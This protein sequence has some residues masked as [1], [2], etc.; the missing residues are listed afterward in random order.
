MK[1]IAQLRTLNLANYTQDWLGSQL[2]SAHDSC[3]YR[4]RHTLLFLYYYVL[5]HLQHL[6][7]PKLKYA[8][9]MHVHAEVSYRRQNSAGYVKQCVKGNQTSNQE[10]LISNTIISVSIRVSCPQTF[11]ALQQAPQNSFL[12]LPGD[13]RATLAALRKAMCLNGPPPK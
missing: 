5:A 8:P 3:F 12:V 11:H 9:L 10:T 6:N 4:H 13:N 1:I 2:L 7:S